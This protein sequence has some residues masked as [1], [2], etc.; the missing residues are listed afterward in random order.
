MLRRIKLVNK[1]SKTHPMSERS[2]NSYKDL[3]TKEMMS[4]D[5]SEVEGMEGY[6]CRCIIC[7]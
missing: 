1:R 2:M 6:Y 4:S 5:D 3:L 7:F